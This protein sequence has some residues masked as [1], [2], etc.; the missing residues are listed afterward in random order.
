M[1]GPVVHIS[2]H[3][4]G[5]VLVLSYETN[6]IDKYDLAEQ[7]G[8]ELIEAVKREDVNRVVVDMS[9]VEFMSSVGYGPLVSLRSFIRRDGGKMAL[10][11]LKPMIK[12]MFEETRLLINPNSP[13]SLFINAATVDEAVQMI[14]ESP[15]S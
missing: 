9:K 8:L 13:K 14:S 15:A 5:D 7:I 4:Q 10:C 3:Q 11:G 2:V 1:T 12:M 6:R